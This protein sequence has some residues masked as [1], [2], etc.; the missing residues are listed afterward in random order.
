[1]KKVSNLCFPKNN[2]RSFPK[3]HLSIIAILS[4]A[5]IFSLIFTSPVPCFAAQQQVSDN[6][7]YVWGSDGA[8]FLGDYFLNIIAASD[9]VGATGGVSF[10]D[11]GFNA[12]V[13]DFSGS[14]TV[15]VEGT[16]GTSPAGFSQI[17]I[18]STA[19]ANEIG[20]MF[21]GHVTAGI[22]HQI[23][24][25]PDAASSFLVPGKTKITVVDGEPSLHLKGFQQVTFPLPVTNW[26]NHE[27]TVSF[28]YRLTK[29]KR[30]ESL[31]SQLMIRLKQHDGEKW[32]LEE[33][34]YGF[35][36]GE[37]WNEGTLPFQFSKNPEEGILEIELTSGEA[38]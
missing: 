13:L 16:V 20:I 24:F 30:A 36:E 37:N 3:T 25:R 22:I 18:D 23:E 6:G 38:Y 8:K 33:R 14:G 17:T 12:S 7:D 5:V 35:S 32:I 15:T 27:V 21:N 19:G 31:T 4:L 9:T 2:G 11:N 34:Q 29:E 10:D 1:M 28:Q 26:G